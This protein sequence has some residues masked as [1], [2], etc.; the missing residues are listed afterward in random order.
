MKS[1]DTHMMMRCPCRLI[2]SHPRKEEKEDLAVTAR[3]GPAK[4]AHC[5]EKEARAKEAHC[6]EKEARAKEAHC[7]EKEVRAKEALRLAKEVR[8]LAKEALR[9]A[10]EALRL[11]KE[12]HGQVERVMAMSTSTEERGSVAMKEMPSMTTQMLN[13]TPWNGS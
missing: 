2:Q 8:R 7:L 9:L 10:K 3:V 1:L 12:A 4:E 6:L 13:L 11:V 5:L